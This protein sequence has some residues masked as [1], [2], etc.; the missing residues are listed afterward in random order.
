MPTFRPRFAR[1]CVALALVPVIEPSV[2]FAGKA[3]DGDPV[4][5][6]AGS[7][8]EP[9]GTVYSLG[10]VMMN[11]RMFSGEQPLWGGEQL[12]AKD[13]GASVY[14]DRV[15]RVILFKGSIARLT[16][17]RGHDNAGHESVL[18]VV[19]AVGQIAVSL[20]PEALGR[21][22]VGDSVL[23]ASRGSS[24]RVHFADGESTLKVERG[25]VIR[26]PQRP[27]ARYLVTPVIVDPNEK[28]IRTGPDRYSVAANKTL[29]L[30]VLLKP[31]L[32]ASKTSSLTVRP[33]TVRPMLAG[34]QLPEKDQPVAGIDVEF[35]LDTPAIGS[36][37]PRGSSCQTVS[38]NQFGVAV[39]EFRA[40]RDKG[41][42]KVKATVVVSR[43]DF[44]EGEI[45]VFKPPGIFRPR[46]L[47]IG[48][49]VLGGTICIIKFRPG[50]GP[51]PLRQVPPPSI[52]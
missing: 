16:S 47:I 26:D 25:V 15:G 18:T 7:G 43:D 19:L 50:G 3:R 32:P 42:S 35:C 17:N 8:F 52:P 34:Y 1:L 27:R 14:L 9:I 33:I 41:A 37:F 13:A 44:W 36:F 38:T 2:A 46:N 6:A 28:P 48:A 22:E 11:G 10:S 29:R 51:G 31:S 24:F 4:S 20:E 40:G 49:A 5:F 30:R 23:R 21:V 12:W 39:A 45:E